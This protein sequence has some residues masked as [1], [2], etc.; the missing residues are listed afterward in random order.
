MNPNHYPSG[1]KGGQF[2]P[3]NTGVTEELIKKVEPKKKKRKTRPIN[4]KYAKQIQSV[5]TK[6]GEVKINE[7]SIRHIISH[8]HGF[9]LNKDNFPKIVETLSNPTEIR[10]ETTNSKNYCFYLQTSHFKAEYCKVIVDK[11]R[12]VI[13]AFPVKKVDEKERKVK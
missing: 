4:K 9:M 7:E 13:S 3:K 8:K 11:K 10:R 6:I 1:K 12:N 2:A 5:E